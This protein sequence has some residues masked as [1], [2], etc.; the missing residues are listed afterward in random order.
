MEINEYLYKLIRIT[1]V[2]ER[3][4]YFKEKTNFEKTEYRLLREILMER[5]RG[6]QIISSE[7]ARRL[8]VTR[9]AVSQ[10]VTKL[11]RDGIVKRMASSTDRKIA[12]IE[13]TPNVANELEKQIDDANAFMEKVVEVFGDERMKSYLQE[14]DELFR[15]IDE[16]KNK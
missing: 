13:L 5:N 14:T 3:F 16:I 15:V 4:D 6:E 11:E 9:S 7:L 12:Y 2:F 10:I 1:R 8:G